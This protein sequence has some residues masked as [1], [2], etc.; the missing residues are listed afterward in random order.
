MYIWIANRSSVTAVRDWIPGSWRSAA[1]GMGN[2]HGLCYLV[3]GSGITSLIHNDNDNTVVYQYIY[4]AFIFLACAAFMCIRRATPQHLAGKLLL[5]LTRTIL[6]S[7]VSHAIYR[8]RSYNSRCRN[9]TY[10]PLCART[11][12]VLAFVESLPKPHCILSTVCY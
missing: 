4:R 11:T 6:G 3:C 8:Q 10:T 12:R 1:E 2:G 7:A 5:R 9:C